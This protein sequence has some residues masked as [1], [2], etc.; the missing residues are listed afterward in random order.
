MKRKFETICSC[1]LDMPQRDETSIAVQF[2]Q[3]DRWQ[4]LSWLEYHD[5]ICTVACALLAHDVKPGHKVAIM[6]NTRLEWSLVDLAALSIQAVTVPV[7]QTAT[8]DDLKHILNNA[9]VKVLFIENRSMYK[10]YLKIRDECPTVEKVIC[11]ETI[12]ET[13]EKAIPWNDFFSLGR[14]EKPDLKPKFHSLSQAVK[15]SDMATIIYTS[16]T[17]GL[18]KGVVITH[19][20]IISEVSEAFE[21][22][23]VTSLDVTLSF[24]PY[25][26]VLGR[27]EHWGHS[28]FGFQMAYAE[29]LE[30]VRSNLSEI[31]PTILVSVPRIFEKIYATIFA[32]L[33]NNQLQKK[34]FERALRVGLKAGQYRMDRR[35]LPLALFAELEIARRLVLNKIKEAF[36]GRL[37]FAISGG[38]PI[39]KDIALFFHACDVL[40]LEGYGLTETT[41][42]ICVNAPFNYRFGSVGL[43]IGD[44]RIRLA[45]D[46]EILVKSRKVMKEYYKDPE[47]TSQAL[48]QGW[49]KTG[50]IG[51][52]LPSGDLR[53]TDR[54]KDLIKTAGGKYVAPQK[55]E[56]LLKLNPN[57]SN[58]LIHGDN[59]KYIVALITLN[60]QSVREW[61]RQKNIS[62]QDD[63]SLAQNPAVLEL[64]RK[65]VAEVNTQ[66]GSYETIKRFSIL[67]QDFTVESGELT[68]SLKVKR[69]FL[70]QKFKKQIEALYS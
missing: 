67:N 63:S 60:M 26:H 34:I 14:Q 11:F 25:A 31:R 6:S 62:Y 53:I 42:A 61:A 10:S 57:I 47:S 27:I 68:P 49:F 36:G 4:N 54:K 16:G 64:I 56:N 59:R 3:N 48:D 65:G 44:V 9:E 20:Q 46:G 7:Y 43:P 45:E 39:S 35:P 1:V 24:L 15:A 52:F 12:R 5:K 19:E 41:A 21:Y 38:A 17:T 13:D 69:K 66:L 28:Y 55:L 58:V 33:S 18:P 32:Q 22:C 30:K 70:D 8:S 37:R 40:I 2:K 23:G 51:E 50:D 29:G